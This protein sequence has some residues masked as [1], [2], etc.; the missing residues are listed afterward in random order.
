MRQFVIALSIAAVALG[1]TTA[2]ATKKY[3]RTQVAD[4]NDKVEGLSKTVE[5]TQQRTRKNEQAIGDVDQKADAANR[6]AGAANGAAADARSAANSAGAKADAID[7]ASRRLVYEVVLSDA[8]GNFKFNKAELP[9]EARSKLDEIVNQLQA[10]PKNAWI[11]I[12]GYTDSTGSKVYNKQLGMERAEAVKQYLYDTHH[13]PLH[14]MNVISYGA[15]KPVA[16]NTTRQG[17]AQNRRVVVRVL[18]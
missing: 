9:V 13:I 2:C 3:V 18:A 11:E 1:G 5:D 12:E 7:K 17:R 4:V 8:E 14:K 15:D 16:P 6:A 10:D